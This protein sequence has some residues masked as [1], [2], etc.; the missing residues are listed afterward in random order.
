MTSKKDN[1]AEIKDACNPFKVASL[2]GRRWEAQFDEPDLSSDAGLA[3]LVSSGIADGLL[4]NLAAALDDPRKG[5]VHSTLQLLRQ[6]TFQILGGYY[7]ANDSDHLRDDTVM[8]TA[9]GKALEEGGLASQPTISRLEGSVSKKDLLRMARALFDDYLDSFEGKAPTMIC[10]DMD[11]SAHL[12]YGQQQLGLFN[13]HVGDHCLMPFYVFDG[14]NGRLMTATLRPGKTPTAPEILAIM[15]RLVKAIRK[16]FP[17]TIITFRADSHHTK[18]AV[19]DFFEKENIEF[20][21]GL[22]TNKAL[23]KIFAEDIAQAKAR[24]ERRKSYDE[25]TK[26]VITYTD[27]YYA[28]GTWSGK[29][30]VIARIIAGPQGVD[31][32][33]VVTSFKIAEAKYLYTTVYCGRGEAELFIKECK[34]GLGSN[35]SPCQKATANQFRLFLHAA[36][37]A[38]L[39]RFRSI[40]L[41]GTPWERKTFAEIRLRLFKIA[42]RLEVMKTKVRLHLSV[43]LEATHRVLWE[44]CAELGQ[45]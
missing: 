7:D 41:K 44:R 20:I 34:Q 3:A 33:Y 2:F 21:T 6:R 8:R 24:Y 16:R 25:H 35:T 40:V 13:T 10:V 26:E 37:Y 27:A 38:I 1:S 28:A 22:A 30:R 5:A 42:G 31:V 23:V 14:I 43:A 29:Q 36:A 19:M 12:V 11:P 45:Q 32:R 4:V 18:P 9:A 39:H 15:K 17:R